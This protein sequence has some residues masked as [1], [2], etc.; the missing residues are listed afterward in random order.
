[1]TQVVVRAPVLGSLGCGWLEG[2]QTVTTLPDS[3]SGVCTHVVQEQKWRVGLRLA[4]ALQK[5]NAVTTEEP[6]PGPGSSGCRG[7]AAW[8]PRGLGALR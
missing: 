4:A 1:M 6:P 5:E 3:V 7:A 8:W 2:S